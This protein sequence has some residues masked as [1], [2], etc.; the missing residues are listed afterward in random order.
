MIWE[1]ELDIYGKARKLQGDEAFCDFL[2][3]GQYIDRESGLAFNRNRYYDLESGIYTQQDPIGVEGGFRQYGY[4]HDSNSW[5][6]PY[7]LSGWLLGQNLNKAGQG[8]TQGIRSLDW[9]A[10]HVIPQAVWKNNKDFFKEIGFKGKHS[11]ANGIFLPN[12]AT[13]AQQFG[14]FSVFHNGSHS[15]YSDLVRDRITAIKKDYGVHGDKVR[16]RAE[17][18]DLQKRLKTALSRKGGGAKRLH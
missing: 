6:D 11:A 18:E 4:V 8:V 10:H 5:I 15:D 17:M 1:R 3:Q 2:W 14:G 12:S 7:G 16:A 9:Q 13:K